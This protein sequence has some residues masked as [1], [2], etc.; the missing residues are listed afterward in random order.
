VEHYAGRGLRVSLD[1][2]HD[3]GSKTGIAPLRCE[4]DI[5]DAPMVMAGIEIEPADR[6]PFPQ[7]QQEIRLRKSRH[8]GTMLEIELL[9][10]KRAHLFGRPAERRELVDAERAI[11]FAQESQVIA[12]AR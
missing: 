12:L 5:D 9:V 4:T 8:I 3:R 7:D 11:Q 2:L 6:C 1:C 10:Q